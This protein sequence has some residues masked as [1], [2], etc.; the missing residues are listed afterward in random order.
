MRLRAHPVARLFGTAGAVPALPRGLL[1]GAALYTIVALV[2][3]G[4]CSI[5]AA[6][7]TPAT[8]PDPTAIAPGPGVAAPETEQG[9]AAMPAEP[10]EAREAAGR[11]RLELERAQRALDVYTDL[12]VKRLQSL[13]SSPADS[14]A[15]EQARVEANGLR[16]QGDDLRLQLDALERIIAERKARIAELESQRQLLLNPAGQPGLGID[17]EAELG[18]LGAAIADLKGDV[19]AQAD[20]RSLTAEQL[21][22][23]R[24]RLEL[25]EEW[26]REA[27]QSAEIRAEREHAES[28]R[29]VQQRLEEE[30]QASAA[31]AAELRAQLLNP[32]LT[33]EQRLR[34]DIQGSAAA[35]QAAVTRLDARLTGVNDR[36]REL[37]GL[38]AS[39]R[40]PAASDVRAAI[41]ELI[42][43]QSNLNSASE[44]AARKVNLIES[45]SEL[46]QERLAELSEGGRRRLAPEISALEE[47]QSTLELRV[48][49][50]ADA[51][52]RVRT[53][54]ETLD[55]SYEEALKRGLLEREALPENTAELRALGNA[56]VKAPQTLFYQLWVSLELTFESLV[57][58]STTRWLM[59]A[60]VELVLLWLVLVLRRLVSRAV[61]AM[62]VMAHR[63]DRFSDRVLLLVLRLLD[64]NVWF[65]G[66]LAGV[67]VLA[68]FAEVQQPARGILTA[69]GI[70]LLVVKP[71]VNLTW[72]LVGDP[73][74]GEDIYRPRLFF[75]VSIATIAGGL[76][77]TASVT[78]R[79]AAL[80]DSLVGLVDRLLMLVLLAGT[81]P[82]L[83][84]RAFVL[85]LVRGHYSDRRWFPVAVG[86]SLLAVLALGFAGLIG[87]VG[88]INL[89]LEICRS[90]GLLVALVIAWVL[91]AG[92]LEDLVVWAKNYAVAHAKLGLLWTQDII[93]PLHRLTSLLLAAAV[94]YVFLGL[95][96]WDVAGFAFD[97]VAGMLRTNLF[98]IGETDVTLLM[99][100]IIVLSAW[101]VLAVSRWLRNVTYRWVYS[102]I[103]D[104]GVRHSLSVFTQYTA[105]V[106]GVMIVLNISGID[107]TTLTVFAGALGVG[108]GFG[109]QTIANNFISGILLL[110][111]RPLRAGDL[112]QVG[113]SEGT[114]TR[115]GMR[116]L[117]LE[118]WDKQEV[119]IPNSDVISNAFTNWTHSDNTLRSVLMV[120]VTYKADPHRVQ[121]L[122][123][124]VLKKHPG[125][126][127]DPEYLVLLW[128]FGENGMEF[129]VQ[130]FFDVVQTNLLTLRSEVMFGIWN[131]L[132]KNGIEIPF[133]QRDLYIKS[134]APETSASASGTLSD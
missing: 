73:R 119:I 27:Q 132:D 62:T 54:L 43:I 79:L 71:F 39:G 116:S 121:R 129:R 64:A 45:D 6:Q 101:A 47:I 33:P 103:I 108:L 95:L 123:E 28:R 16:L 105:V 76:L 82:A 94:I 58:A 38:A 13:E 31:R 25:A 21:Q 4:W 7:T 3:L 15:V 36:L 42:R 86:V 90:L 30:A 115:I 68:V 74:L 12:Q 128:T 17:R 130:Y 99:I 118:T 44:L 48:Q 23:N 84:L 97:A 89:A 29:D 85:D 80:P 117:T 69:V 111:E 131:T 51:S 35:E 88:Y 37:G 22:L 102:R 91:V 127:R 125:V 120:R 57:H 32:D 107:L 55:I 40:A 20:Q 124:E 2:L 46:L 5:A 34:L 1:L 83:R 65:V 81:A 114:V 67:L 96:G 134:I 41:N 98:R 8:D 104:L 11:A 100:L 18:R 24:Q 63:G 133:P 49:Q 77:A 113:G 93:P 78:A 126:L 60:A 66:A 110:A 70:A 122:I 50:L 19:E 56:L 59:L 75:E 72:L 10:S 14:R 109:L 92:L 61:R 26:L 87:L 52:S 9:A 112:V 53:M 106:V